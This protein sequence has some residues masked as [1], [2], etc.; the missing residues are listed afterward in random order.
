MKLIKFFIGI[1]VISG[2][3]LILIGKQQILLPERF[4]DQVHK[5]NLDPTAL[6]YTESS[7]T[8]DVYFKIRLK[9]RLIPYDE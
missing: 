2:F 1:I 8:S 6:F 9:K 3:Y 5:H 4:V 7:V